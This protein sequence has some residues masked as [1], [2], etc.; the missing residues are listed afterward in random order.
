MK[1]GREA[2]DLGPSPSPPLLVVDG[3]LAETAAVQVLECEL[4]QTISELKHV[5]Q[6]LAE[7]RAALSAVEEELSNAQAR[8]SH[9][10]GLVA[11]VLGRE[12]GTLQ[13]SLSPVVATIRPHRV[14]TWPLLSA[15]LPP[16]PPVHL[17]P[18]HRSSPF[19]SSLVSRTSDRLLAHGSYWL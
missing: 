5:N 3:R 19:P 10:A 12:V 8:A 18:P 7:A 6:Q 9:D 11:N 2:F 17:R 13:S 15:L 14:S 1:V 16:L 4:Q